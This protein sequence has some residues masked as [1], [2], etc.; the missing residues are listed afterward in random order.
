[1]VITS[2][3]TNK[4]PN[5]KVSDQAV[6]IY[7]AKIINVEDGSVLENKA[8]LIDSGKIR[9]IGDFDTLNS[10]V[11]S[12]NA[13]D[14]N[15]KFIIP[16]LWDM[17]VHIEGEDLVE[18]NL[19]LLP[20]YI[21]YGIT[22]V[23][24]M[25]SDLGEQVLIW[26]EE[27]EQGKILGPQIFT[28]GRKLEGI[29]SIWKGD[30][31]IA[32]EQDLEQMLNKLEAYKVDL[33]KITENTLPGPLFLKSVKEA[34]K[35]GF[36]V[37]GHVPIDLTIDQLVEAGFSSIE[38]ASYLLRLGA[39]EKNIVKQLASGSMTKSEANDY[40]SSHFNQETA[41]EA[42]KKLGETNIAITPTLI[43]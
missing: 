6:L 7:N 31:E 37:S 40:Y 43:G 15:N 11:K 38:H 14:V 34:K 3:N 41:N 16:G 4:T 10:L 25:A 27:L 26:R 28:A 9:A 32:S 36:L 23:R 33:V 22:T 20:V 24:D 18:D 2:C 35:R 8:I 1:M 30:L 21:A 12:S 19:A 42:Y 17:H 29:N 5:L 13:I 39:D